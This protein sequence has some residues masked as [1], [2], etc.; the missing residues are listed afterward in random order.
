VITNDVGYYK[1]LFVRI[2]HISKLS[3]VNC[4]YHSAQNPLSSRLL[5]KKLYKN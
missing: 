5:S 1:N 2:A 3:A 4:Y